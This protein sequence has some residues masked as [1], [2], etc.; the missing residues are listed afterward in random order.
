MCKDK[1]HRIALDNYI[2]DVIGASENASKQFI[3]YTR[4][5][6]ESANNASK[7]KVIPGW[8]D[9]VAPKKE[10]AKFHYQLWLCANK[11]LVIC[12]IIC[13]TLEISLN[14]Q[15]ENASTQRNLSREISL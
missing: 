5:P 9:L 13:V 7:R 12:S 2:E 15:K 8:N 10:E 3:P 11:P 14:M 4:A 6:R 1:S